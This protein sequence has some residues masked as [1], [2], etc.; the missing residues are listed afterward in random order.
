MK[1]HVGVDARRQ[2]VR[3]ID[4]LHCDVRRI[5]SFDVGVGRPI[6]RQRRRLA[7]Q[8]LPEFEQ[9]AVQQGMSLQH[10]LP[11]IGKVRLQSVRHKIS[12]AVPRR[13]QTF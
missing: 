3:G 6:R 2:I 5:Q 7:F 13:N 10:L 9:I 11:R 1:S 12:A 4:R 8:H